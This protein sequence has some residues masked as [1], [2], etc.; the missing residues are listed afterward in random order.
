MF[1]KRSNL[2]KWDTKDKKYF[3]LGTFFSLLTSA[4]AASL[5]FIITVLTS[6]VNNVSDKNI[7]QNE[8]LS[9]MGLMIGLMILLG[10]ISIICAFIS[11][12]FLSKLSSKKIF[13]IRTKIFNNIQYLSPED[14]KRYDNSSLMTRITID[15]YN[16][17]NFYNFW[18]VNVFPSIV[19][20]IVFLIMSFVLN[21]FIALILVGISIFLYSIV[22]LF[23]RMSIVHYKTNLNKIDELNK[24][25]QENIIG[26]KVIKSFNLFKRQK[27]RFDIINK[28][29]RDSGIKA[30][31]KAYISW[32]FSIALV[33]V[34]SI[35]IILIA[36]IFNWKG[37]RFYGTE[38]NASV[39]V[40]LVSYSYL[41]LWSAFD[42][43]FLEIYR[44][45]CLT[46]KKR[47]WEIINLKTTNINNDGINFEHGSIE[48]KN[49]SFK[50]NLNSIDYVLKN[51]SFKIDK[52]SSLGIIGQTGSGKTTLL[53]LLSRLYDPIEGQILI[54]GKDIKTINT[55]SLLDS[56]SFAFQK[57]LL[58]SGTLEENIKIA[59]ESICETELKNILKISQLED[60][61]NSKENG[62]KYELQ[63]RGTNL[64][65]G[66]Q[67]RL[68]IA[69][70]L[71]KK[72]N[73]Y[74][75]DDTTSALDNITEN[76]ILT[77]LFN[78]IT[79]STIILSSQKISSIKE[80]D[81]IIVLD[82]GKISGIGKHDELLKTNLIYK[83]IYD[84]QN[85][86]EINNE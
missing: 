15:V 7:N 4:C 73:I 34:A 48:F 83:E 86:K 1:L 51:V 74:I 21:Y 75:F 22:F 53:M 29:A 8:S 66:Q 30:D 36:T 14:L 81:T 27:R 18:L 37:I 10:I 35:I 19:R 5:P 12:N 25:T 56:I 44:A 28:E 47:M 16:Y 69:R 31:T 54:N 57:K 3:F 50:Y 13:E 68:N 38:I 79:N 85:R 42:L 62:I 11:K 17:N 9:F 32:P 45:R 58:F 24:I 84:F 59:N 49:V 70:A 2:I 65:G 52:N 72:A 43:G 26:S 80:L 41:I 55:N 76:K 67:Q 63:E 71:A 39:I 82:K 78:N 64:S 33:N 6:K 60:F 20:W 40:G 46:S 23:S 77:S 61:V